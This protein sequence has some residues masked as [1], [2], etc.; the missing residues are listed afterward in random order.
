MKAV[1]NKKVVRGDTDTTP[2]GAT[3]TG[4]N[5][6]WSGAQR[7]V[8][9][10]RAEQSKLVPVMDP[11]TNGVMYKRGASGQSIGSYHTRREVTGYEEREFILDDLGNGQVTKVYGR[12]WNVALDGTKS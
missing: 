10:E 5:V 1:A 9:T 7:R 6:N 11:H 3:W 2:T 12:R 8:F 4:E